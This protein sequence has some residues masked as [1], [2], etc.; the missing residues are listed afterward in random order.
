MNKKYNRQNFLGLDSQTQIENTDVA[1]IGN[2]GGGSHI[3][4]QLLHIGFKKIKVFDPDWVEE[5]NTH[6]LVGINYPQDVLNQV[7][8]IEVAKRMALNIQGECSIET[9]ETSW[10]EKADKV[11]ECKIVLGCV[12]SFDQRDQLENFCRRNDIYYIDIGMGVITN[13]GDPPQMAGQVI[14]SAPKGPC[15]RCLGFITEE[16]LNQDRSRY[17][18]AGPQPQ[19]IWCNGTL[20]SLAVGIAVDIVTK[21][22]GRRDNVVYLSYDANFGTVEI[23]PRLKYMKFSECI[24]H[25][26]NGSAK[27]IDL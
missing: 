1:V 24:H 19:V 2:G 9:Y 26:E 27:Y 10:Q 12:D 6:R 21:W 23:H 18:D 14:L 22:T 5:S 16:K 4:Q 11:K 3:I 15:M 20:A 8:K 13:V 7:P 25:T 17:G